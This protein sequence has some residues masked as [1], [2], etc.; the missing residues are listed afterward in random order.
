M[1]I[2]SASRISSLTT[3]VRDDWRRAWP[4]MTVQFLSPRNH[5]STP[6]VDRPTTSSLRA[7]T[8]FI[9]TRTS[10]LT[11][12][13]YSAPRRATWIASA[14]AT[15]VF[16]GVHPVFTQVPPNLSRSIIATVLPAPA[17]RTARGGPAWP[18]PIMIASKCFMGVLNVPFEVELA[19]NLSRKYRTDCTPRVQNRIERRLIL[20]SSLSFT[21]CADLF[22]CGY[23]ESE[24]DVDSSTYEQ[25]KPFPLSRDNRP[26]T[27]HRILTRRSLPCDPSGIS[28]EDPALFSLTGQCKEDRCPKVDRRYTNPY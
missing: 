11:T 13:P 3:T 17:N 5:S 12:K 22:A 2:L 14:L 28:R 18:V 27:V 16:V 4:W 21:T 25:E 23:L 7:L 10:P 15:S 20:P 9:S 19:H 24:A 26:G 8:R 1:K 6:L